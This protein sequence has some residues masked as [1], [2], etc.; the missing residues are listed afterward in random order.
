[1]LRPEIRIALLQKEK[2]PQLLCYSRGF[3]MDLTTLAEQL[4][5]LEKSY[6]E[7][8]KPINAAIQ[9][10]MR[11]VNKN[12]YTSDDF[13]NAIKEVR[14][15]QTNKYNWYEEIYTF[16]D[17][18]CPAYL[19]ATAQQRAEARAAASDKNGILSALLGYVHQLAEQIHSPTDEK[20]L[21]NGLA[22][23]SIENCSQDF[24]DVLIALA[25]LFVSAE[26]AGIDPK[27]HFKSV[28]E[29]SSDRKP[30]GGSTSVAEML[31][32]FHTYAVLEERRRTGIPWSK[33]SLNR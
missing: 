31:T 10:N 8:A 19:D 26:M 33:R 24:R 9:E 15:K 30:R 2:P 29:L 4:E 32:K 12:G 22:A 17:Q 6:Q 18:L 7:W 20:W 28:A 5:E 21:V 13:Q 25:E 14:D 11:K 27:P 16:F 1:M 3:R 23:V